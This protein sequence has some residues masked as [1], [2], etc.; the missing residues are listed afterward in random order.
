MSPL[1]LFALTIF[2]ALRL[3]LRAMLLVLSSHFFRAAWT[4]SRAP[5]PQAPADPAEWPHVT[6]Q[7]P[8]RNEYYV[9]E[10]V[11][12]AVA[13]L[14]YPRG[15]L[16]IQ[17]LDDST[18]ATRER[19]AEI[20]ASL[21][22]EGLDI[23]HVFRE[24]PI[25]FK[26]GA[27]NAALPDAKGEFVAMF[28]SDCVPGPDF[29]RRTLPWFSDPSVACVQVRWAFLNR[30][31]SLLTRVQAL[32]LDGLFAVDQFSRA[33][34]RLPLQF[35]GTNGVWR[36]VA[37]QEVGQWSP[38]ILA[39]DAD[40]S[41]RAYLAGYRVA[42]LRDYT[43][44]TE[45]PT[46]MAAFR[47]QQRRWAL[48]SAQ[49]LR[50]LTLPIL[51]SRLSWRAKLMMFMHLGRHSID[52]LVLLAC[53]TTPLTTLYG[54]PFLVDYGV[55]ANIAIVGLVL[56][57]ALAFYARALA[58]V[59]AKRRE[60]VLVPCIILL[61][62]GLS[63]VYTAAVFRGLVGSGGEFVRTPKSGDATKRRVGPV[64]RAPVDIA[65]LVEIA[66]AAAH[67]YFTYLALRAAYYPYAAF[68]ATAAVA[69]GWVGLG[70]LA[71]RLRRG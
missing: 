39:E 34:Q 21:A 70:S 22:A 66:M 4:S 40:L 14:D 23:S 18:D 2:E 37:L 20:C 45:L 71:S 27:L 30:D 46:E 51:R 59:G 24:A 42:H 60:V 16:Q 1:V 44:P 52:P 15:K 5:D 10:R 58:Q 65:V 25:G 54:M 62:I 64:Y 29:L 3:A 49:M 38:A 28:D 41:F 26:A 19:A 55:V 67:G 47:A 61:A 56:L 11:V 9:V 32:V 31:R 8:V 33:A 6:V 57:S 48:G 43:V 7:I 17:V 12:R 36:R 50:T 13:G 63:I 53:V 68:F 69:F 35:N